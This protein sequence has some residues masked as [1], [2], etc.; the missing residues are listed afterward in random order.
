MDID[1]ARRTFAS[2]RFA[3]EL[4]G[5][6]ITAAGNHHAE[7]CLKLD[8]RHLNARGVAMG[9]VLFTLADFAAAVAANIQE[10]NGAINWVSLNATIHY[11][12]P[13]TGSSLTAVCTAIKH[14]RSTALYQTDILCDGR[15]VAVVETTMIHI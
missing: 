6:E 12:V 5:A 10:E 13:A 3:T 8:E 7:C 2:D 14:G 11:L 9:G 15:R 4:T 1:I